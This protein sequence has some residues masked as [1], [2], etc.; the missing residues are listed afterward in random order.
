[1]HGRVDGRLPSAATRTLL[2]GKEHEGRG[3]KAKHTTV[4]QGAL[5]VEGQPWE[6]FW[7]AALCEIQCSVVVLS[8]L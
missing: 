4:S 6:K 1:M 8:Y 7:L 5:E 3:S 2:N